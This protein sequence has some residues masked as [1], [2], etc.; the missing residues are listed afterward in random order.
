MLQILNHDD[1][2]DALAGAESLGISLTPLD[3]TLRRVLTG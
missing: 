2:I 3:E 1:A